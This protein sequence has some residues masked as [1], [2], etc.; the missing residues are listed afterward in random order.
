MAAPRAGLIAPGLIGL[1]V[2]LRLAAAMALAQPMVSDAQ[3]YFAMA[4][5]A[6]RLQPLADNFGQHAFYSPGYP[7]A[8]A[9]FFALFGASLSVALAVNALLAGLAAG[10]ILALA[11]ALDLPR[12]AGGLAA[13]IH[14]LWLPAL[15]NGAV[16]ARENLSTPLMLLVA[17][18]AVRIARHGPAPRRLA[19]AGLACGLALLAGT[20][21]LGLIAGPAVALLLATRGALAPLLRGGLAL[22][23]G[24][25]VVLGPW[26]AANHAATGTATLSSSA[27]FNLYLGNNPRATGRFVSISDT[28]AGPEWHALLAREGEVGAG[29]ELGRRAKAWIAAEPG[30]AMALAARKLAMF[31]APNLPKPGDP[32]KIALVKAA[33]AAQFLL[34][35]ALG[36]AGLMLVPLRQPARLT[37][38]ALLGAFWATHA[39]TYIIDRYREPAMPLLMLLAAA[40]VVRFFPKGQTD[41]A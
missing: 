36:L 33:G 11:R 34:V 26:L 12:A 25:A 39:A 24:L 21:A 1:T 5:H 18:L 3:A 28:P 35:L 30:T 23:L 20:S 37:I 4:A 29:A 14:A 9:P 17:L 10:L 19:M 38:A 16:L 2:A 27:G 7:L 22:A 15:L 31:W 6:A 13:L 40:V 8:L 32:A 41:A